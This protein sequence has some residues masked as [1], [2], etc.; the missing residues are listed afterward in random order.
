MAKQCSACCR[1][2]TELQQFS[3]YTAY[4][5]AVARYLLPYVNSFDG[6]PV[7]QQMLVHLEPQH[8]KYQRMLGNSEQGA[9]YVVWDVDLHCRHSCMLITALQLYLAFALI[10]RLCFITIC[11]YSFMAATCQL[12]CHAGCATE[13]RSRCF[14]GG[15]EIITCTACQ[16]ANLKW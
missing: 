10:S 4:I 9:Y 7:S 8:T 3:G 15:R 16:S 2:D 14:G 5:L 11:K 6:V 1:S 13:C 12:P